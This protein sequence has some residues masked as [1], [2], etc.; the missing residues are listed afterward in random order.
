MRFWLDRDGNVADAF[1]VPYNPQ[2]KCYGLLPD[3]FRV[4][5]KTSE[6]IDGD[7]HDVHIPEL[8]G[9]GGEIAAQ[10]HE[11]WQGRYRR[12]RLRVTSVR[13]TASPNAGL[14]LGRN[15]QLEG[16]RCMAT[17]I[18]VIVFIIV[19]AIGNKLAD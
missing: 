13:A 1:N 18:V 11:C 16:D 6:G 8:D 5:G 15:A 2:T 12:Y 9:C 17:R 14:R 10:G 19:S 4:D 7:R 3:R